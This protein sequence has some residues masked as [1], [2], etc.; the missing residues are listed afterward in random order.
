MRKKG[1]LSNLSDT[2]FIKLVNES[3][4]IMDIMRKLG[5]VATSGGVAEAINRRIKLL[6]INIKHFTRGRKNR[7]INNSNTKHKIED[8]LVE[9][10][11]YLN[12]CALKKKL[13]KYGYLKYECVLCKNNGEWM[14]NSL[15]LHL[16]HINGIY[17]DNRIENL[18]I[19]CPNCHS[20]TETYS[21]KNVNKNK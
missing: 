2:E 5:Y 7:L 13:I 14:N 18:R 16:D 12:R 20:Q 21:G 19:L 4:S 3:D 15:S 11:N 1:K 9:N 8:I 17:N 6:N 10:S